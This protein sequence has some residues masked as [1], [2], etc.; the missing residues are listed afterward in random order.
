MVDESRIGL[1]V[2]VVGSRPDKVIWPV[3]ELLAELNVGLPVS[4]KFLAGDLKG[5]FRCQR[6]FKIFR[7]YASSKNHGR[8]SYIFVRYRFGRERREGAR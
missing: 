7:H 5:L 1:L 4:K 2:G 3:G 6:E 8:V